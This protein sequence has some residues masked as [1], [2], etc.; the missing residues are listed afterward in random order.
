MFSKFLLSQNWLF[1]VPMLLGIVPCVVISVLYSRACCKKAYALGDSTPSLNGCGGF[2]PMLHID[3][4]GLIFFVT[5]GLGWARAWPLE[6][7]NFKN[8][9]K[10]V[11][12][13][14][15]AGLK[16][17]VMLFLAMML[18]S[19]LLMPLAEVHVLF[20]GMVWLCLYTAVLS[21]SFA[22]VQLLPV[23]C[24]G[25]YQVFLW[26]MSE[27]YRKKVEKMQIPLVGVLL[28]LL[29]AGYLPS[30][31]ASIVGRV[32]EPFCVFVPFSMVEYYFL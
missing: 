30:V 24:F 29:W 18:V 12:L 1:L 28:V 3:L 11:L 15:L 8:P 4:V 6:K 14:L 7:K 2:H 21:C 20:A 26:L 5:G 17:C 9:T 25:L 31:F 13:I 10:D 22:M 16:Q 27:K 23:P 32:I 19:G